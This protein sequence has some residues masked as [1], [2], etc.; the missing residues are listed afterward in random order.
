MKKSGIPEIIKKRIE[1]AK[2]FYPLERKFQRRLAKVLLEGFE[3]L[4]EYLNM[5]AEE[6]NFKQSIMN[7]KYIVWK[8]GRKNNI[9]CMFCYVDNA[10]DLDMFV[11]IFDNIKK[12]SPVF[13]YAFVH[14]KKDGDTVFDIFRYSKF[15]YMEHCNR[16]KYP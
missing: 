15:S 16:V 2:L 4:T 11:K 12:Y 13:T 6:K 7:K 1:I 3:K 5:L 10:M 8:H 14:Q 9:E